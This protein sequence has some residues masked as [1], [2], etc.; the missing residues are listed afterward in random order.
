M[1]H[2]LNKHTLAHGLN[3]ITARDSD[4]ENILKEVGPPPLW[5]REPGFPTLVHIILEHV[6]VLAPEQFLELDNATLKSIGV[7]RQKIA[8]CRNLARAISAGLLDLNEL[9]SQDERSIRS[10]LL[11][12][13]GIGHW[14]INI[15]LL[16]ALGRVDIWPS[17]DL[18]LAVSIQHVKKLKSRPSQ[19]EVSIIGEAWRPWR[20]VATF[21]LWHYY[22]TRNQENTTWNG[23]SHQ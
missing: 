23:D 12:I 7:S 8:Y 15:Y 5:R 9:G 13:K 21:L 3:V 2:I 10:E 20:S 19:S 14:T 16:M 17:G 4:M 1:M 22:L 6:S 11:K 18:A